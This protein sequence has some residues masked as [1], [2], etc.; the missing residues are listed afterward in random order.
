[1]KRSRIFLGAT[2]LLLAIAALAAKKAKFTETVPNYTTNCHRVGLG[3]L[4]NSGGQPI[5]GY[6][7]AAGAAAGCSSKTVLFAGE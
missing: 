4:F 5:I 2:T 6:T 7:N 3:T 1:M